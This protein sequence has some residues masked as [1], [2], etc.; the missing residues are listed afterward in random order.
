[1]KRKMMVLLSAAS[2][3]LLLAG[4]ALAGWKEDQAA[5]FQ[6]IPVK[7][8]D[9]IDNSNW[10]KVKD[11][12]PPSVVNYVKKG[13]FILDIDEMKWEYGPDAEYKKTSAGNAGKYDVNEQGQ[14]IDNATGKQPVYVEG[15]P[16]PSIDWKNDPKAGQK[17]AYNQVL[18]FARVGNYWCDW[19]TYW[20]G[21]KAGLERTV[22]GRW[23]LNYFW[24]RPDGKTANPAGTIFNE[25]VKVTQPYDVSGILNLT[26]R[27]I[28]SDAD[29]LWAYVP[30][31]RRVKK[32][33]GA[34][35]S[36]PFLG[37]DFV[38][39]DAF[40][41]AGKVESMNWK[42]IGEKTVLMPVMKWATEGPA[43][44]RKHTDGSWRNPDN[45]AG[46]LFGF[47]VPG[48]KGAPWAPTDFVYVPRKM[49]I[50]EVN[51]KDRYYNYGLTHLYLDPEAGFIYK[52]V[53][54]RAG[55]YWKTLMVSYVPAAWAN[56]VTI[57]TATGYVVIDD[58]T[59]HASS[60]S[61]FGAH[62]KGKLENAYFDPGVK[63]TMFMPT[64]MGV[65]SK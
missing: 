59:D 5:L 43:K 7:P 12:L 14:L 21:R 40:A 6:Q 10:E 24:N 11:L 65:Q 36:S 22:S 16:F 53:N 25:Y 62:P 34:N 33:S 61:I 64:S 50:I 58:K 44:F 48:W 27:Y 3:A 4:N 15:E 55:Q 9:R 20:V 38:N 13:D 32:T 46:P 47:E 30:A 35:R 54:D 52:Y 31:I 51:A 63:P 2:L 60:Q 49:Y 8:G 39:D 23:Y 18:N 17:L 28:N 45:L 1:M 19:H 42:V 37:S 29:D 56:K 41:F 57:S 26:Y